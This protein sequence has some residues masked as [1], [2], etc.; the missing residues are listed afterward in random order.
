MNWIL[1]VPLVNFDLCVCVCVC[2]CVGLCVCVCV[3]LLDLVFEKY[4]DSL[5]SGCTMILDITGMELRSSILD[6]HLSAGRIWE[7]FMR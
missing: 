2:V 1:V 6:A 7:M 4:R 5:F 3:A